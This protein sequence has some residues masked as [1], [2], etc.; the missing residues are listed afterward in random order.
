MSLPETLDDIADR[1]GITSGKVMDL[2]DVRAAQ[3]QLADW[4][5][6]AAQER[7]PDALKVLAGQPTAAR[8][9]AVWAHG[10]E[11]WPGVEDIAKALDAAENHILRLM[12][13]MA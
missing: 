1:L 13:P 10:C 8:L 9:E 3:D 2:T 7:W 6:D 11:R 12:E 5:V 4:F